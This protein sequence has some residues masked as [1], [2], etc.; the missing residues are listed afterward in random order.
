[1][2]FHVV[3]V[4]QHLHAR[5][6]GH[7][8][9]DVDAAALDVDQAHA[10]VAGDGQVRVPAEIGDEHA[11]LERDLQ[12]RLVLARLDCLPVYEDFRHSRF[13]S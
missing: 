10:A 5:A 8:A 11:V 3:G 7:V 2:R 6:D 1:M 4:G 12:D 9:G 13:P